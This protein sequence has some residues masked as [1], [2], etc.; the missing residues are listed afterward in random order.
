MQVTT[1]AEQMVEK[2]K[3][4]KFHGM[5]LFW[6]AL[7]MLFD[8]FDLT[9]Y[10]AVV[11]TLMDEWGISAVQAGMYG[12]YALFGMMFGALIFGTLADKLGRKKII[13]ICVFI[14]SLF[15]L[16]AGLAPSPELFGLFRFITGLGLGG[17]MPNVIGLI[18]EYSPEGLRSRMIATIMAGY[19]IGGVVAA[20]LSMILITN[21]G[22]ESVFFFGALPLLFLPFLA[23]SLPDSV[24]SLVAKNDHKGI[25]KILV[26][27][28][29][30]LSAI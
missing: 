21:F 6:G 23:K 1:N 24:G 28:N 20:F 15:M 12:S 2:A 25:Q 9:I 8:G 19:S 13:M 29:A 5:L 16:L 4:S 18:S 10:G 14:F 3:F 27:V 22:W 26:K 7:L 17:M 30:N 11:P